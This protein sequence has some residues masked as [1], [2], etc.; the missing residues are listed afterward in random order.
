MSL[1]TTAPPSEGVAPMAAFLADCASAL[2]GVADGELADA[3]RTFLA[4]GTAALRAARG[5]G[6]VQLGLEV[7]PGGLSALYP[8][9][10]ATAHELLDGGTAAEFFFM[11]K[12]PGLRVRF[13]PAPGRGEFVRAE[14]RRHAERWRAAGLVRGV[15]SAVYEPEAHLFGG[16]ESMRH[17]HRLFTVDSLTWLDHH[18]TAR[19]T[20][21]WA[22]SLLML[23][24]VFD[25]LR[26]VGWE[27][28]D[29]WGRVADSGRRTPPGSPPVEG[30]VTARLR[31]HWADPDALAA[32]LPA[33]V[34]ALADRHAE[35]VRPLCRRWWAEYFGTERAVV[36][37]REAACY[38]TVF[39]WNRA[40]LSPGT[41][42]LITT[43]LAGADGRVR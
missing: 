24:A 40:A 34:R 9:L 29:V 8:E 42:A 15:R 3:Q 12:P 43:A 35:Q 20:P 4:A 27:D 32:A 25:G 26:V 17:V 10:A 11:H 19:K 37:P 14:V 13:A 41:Q 30:P 21:A 38:H 6:W 33:D 18:T 16:D 7:A 1:S 28:R 5:G 36:G 31:A 2:S 39:H 22:L 23:R